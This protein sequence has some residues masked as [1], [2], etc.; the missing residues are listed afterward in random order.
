M[1]ELHIFDKLDNNFKLVAIGYKKGSIENNHE[2]PYVSDNMKV[3]GDILIAK[4]DNNNNLLDID[5]NFYEEI[6]NKLFY[7]DKKYN[8]Y[9]EED[10]LALDDIDNE[11]EIEDELE[12]LEDD[13]DEDL[14]DVEEED[15]DEDEDEDLEENIDALSQNEVDDLYND[16]ENDNDTDQD[17]EVDDMEDD[18]NVELRLKNIDLFENLL[19]NNKI[20]KVIEDSIFRFTNDKS[21]ERK[22]IRKWDNPYLEKYI[23]IKADQYIPILTH[24]HILKIIR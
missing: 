2:I 15:E 8:D 1:V 10:G 3:Y 21:I 12:E 11:I 6:Y 18:I 23:S 24:N 7:N 13:L 14:E 5:S 22:V 17:I 4:L 16:N 9:E 19:N 20:A